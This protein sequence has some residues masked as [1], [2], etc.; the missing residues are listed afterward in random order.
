MVAPAPTGPTAVE[1]GDDSGRT[2]PSAQGDG[3]S[4]GLV[5]PNLIIV[6]AQK[7]GTSGLHYYLGLH[8]EVSMS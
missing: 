7:C 6:G 2:L 5:L 4:R 3:S 1:R 8:P